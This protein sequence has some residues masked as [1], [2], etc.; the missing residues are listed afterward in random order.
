[1]EL[2]TPTLFFIDENLTPLPIATSVLLIGTI[3]I[4]LFRSICRR[5]HNTK[6]LIIDLLTPPNPILF[7]L[8]F[9]IGK[10]SK[11]LFSRAEG[12]VCQGGEAQQPEPRGPG[13][14]EAGERI[15]NR[16]RKMSSL[17]QALLAG[18]A[19]GSSCSSSTSSPPPSKPRSTDR[20]SSSALAQE[21]AYSEPIVER[22]EKRGRRHDNSLLSHCCYHPCSHFLLPDGC[23]VWSRMGKRCRR[24]GVA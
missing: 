9:P 1:M 19:T 13:G 24:A 11:N 16:G 10:L 12:Y 5:A 18:I 2:C 23:L 21:H 14:V 17:V 22:R 20:S 3:S 7:H 4:F 6:E 15:A 8:R